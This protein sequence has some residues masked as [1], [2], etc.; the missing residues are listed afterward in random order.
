[1]LCVGSDCDANLISSSYLKPY[2][3]IC[4]FSMYYAHT[5]PCGPPGINLFKIRVFQVDFFAAMITLRQP[6][7]HS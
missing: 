7:P 4:R 6:Q 2:V 3:Y 5:S 1:M